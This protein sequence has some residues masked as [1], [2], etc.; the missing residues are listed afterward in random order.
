MTLFQ[1]K[2]KREHNHTTINTEPFVTAANAHI[3]RTYAQGKRITDSF[4][5]SVAVFLSQINIEQRNGGPFGAVIV[6]FEG[7]LDANGIGI[8]KPRIIGVGANHV[9]PNNDPSAHAEMEAYRDAAKRQGSS[10]LKGAVLYT[11]CECCPM[12]LSVAN[13]SGISK[14][15]YVNT[16]EQAEIIE[17]SDKLQYDM[18][19][20]SRDQQMTSIN[21]LGND[22][23]QE[24][25]NKLGQHGAVILDE[26]G[27]VFAYGDTDTSIDP[28]G[29]A[30]LN[31]IKSAVKKHA[32]QQ[33]QIGNQEPVFCLPDG[34][35]M[36]CRDIP[37]PAGLITADWARMLRQRDNTDPNNPALDSKTPDPARIIH[38]TDN[39]EAMAVV[40]KHGHS[41]VHQKPEI[42]NK[43]PSLPDTERAVRTERFS[44]RVILSAAADVF[45]NWKR[46]TTA[47][48]QVRY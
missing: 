35:T 11:S 22:E 8:G 10:D 38:I 3:D 33:K 46:G 39:Y 20:L 37:H 18:F 45:A 26:K 29:I 14:I 2:Y 7:G 48:D 1:E 30:S 42:T 47:G 27:T 19:G 34:F 6:E 17:F 4:F 36:V 32:D 16:R 41:H 28:T 31:A 44:G 40:D 24:V 15:S 21:S 13:G 9:V 43:Q 25:R 5:H 23:Q 12:C